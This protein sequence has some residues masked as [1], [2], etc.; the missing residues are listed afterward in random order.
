LPP[1]DLAAAEALWLRP[2]QVDATVWDTANLQEALAAYAPRYR[3]LLMPISIVTGE[4]D[5]L[6]PESRALDASAPGASL[7]VIAG[8]G[9]MVIKTR[10]RAVADAVRAMR[11]PI[12][13]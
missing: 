12:D 4:H 5:D 2:R 10:P 3:E 9:Q 7:T 13:F 11:G 1:E 8:A 6:L